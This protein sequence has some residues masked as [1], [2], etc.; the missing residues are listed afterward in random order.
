VCFYLARLLGE[1]VA[2]YLTTL[3]TFFFELDKSDNQWPEAMIDG[4]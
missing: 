2:E 3:L 4:G 1:E